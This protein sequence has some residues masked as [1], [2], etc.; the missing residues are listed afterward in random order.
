MRQRWFIRCCTALLTAEI[1]SSFLSWHGTPMDWVGEPLHF[2][3]FELWR[4]QSWA[5]FFVA[6]VG[7]WLICWRAFHRRAH[8]IGLWLLASALAVAVEVLTTV[9][10]WRQLLGECKRD[11]APGAAQ[12]L[13]STTHINRRLPTAKRGT[14]PW[15]GHFAIARAYRGQAQLG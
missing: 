15:R 14:I 3:T 6:G 13:K 5:I 7:F 9:R 1:V 4:L 11:R 10:Y 2:W 12:R 8:E